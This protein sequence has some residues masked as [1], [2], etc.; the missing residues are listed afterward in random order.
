MS[1]HPTIEELSETVAKLTKKV[2]ALES[3]KL[4]KKEKK[5]RPPSAYNKFMKNKLPE[6]KKEFPDLNHSELFKKCATLWKE[7]KEG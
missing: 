1:K 4:P 6:L 3:E 7:E 5:S 2:E